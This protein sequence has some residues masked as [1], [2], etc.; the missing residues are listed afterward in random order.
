MNDAV[1][2]FLGG[3]AIAGLPL[4]VLYLHAR[5]ARNYFERDRNG[6]DAELQKLRG[7]IAKCGPVTSE[8]RE[9][10]EREGGWVKAF[11]PTTHDVMNGHAML[12]GRFDLIESETV[13]SM[14]RSSALQNNQESVT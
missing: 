8:V 1:L 13:R 4:S 12:A 10:P 7:V 3:L 11:M 2:A 14:R 9:H 5:E 6:K